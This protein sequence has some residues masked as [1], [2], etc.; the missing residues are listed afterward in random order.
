MKLWEQ[1]KD[2][3]LNRKMVLLKYFNCS[4]TTYTSASSSLSRIAPRSLLPLWHFKHLS[5]LLMPDFT[6]KN[7]LKILIHVTK[8]QCQGMLMVLVVAADTSLWKVCL[9][10]DKV[11]MNGISFVVQ[12]V[13][14]EMTF[15]KFNRNVSFQKYVPLCDTEVHC[16]FLYAL[17]VCV[18]SLCLNLLLSYVLCEWYSSVQQYFYSLLLLLWCTL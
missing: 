18:F 12:K 6:P 3:C 15:S 2:S 13:Q 9:C 16:G 17:S 14:K 8:R 1:K 4:K 7:P 10:S 11:E 5:V